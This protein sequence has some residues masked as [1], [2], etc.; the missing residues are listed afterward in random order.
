MV[1]TIE[2]SDCLAKEWSH[3]RSVQWRI[4]SNISKLLK[5][6]QLFSCLPMRSKI[7]QNCPFFRGCG[8]SRIG[9]CFLARETQN[10]TKKLFF[11]FFL[12]LEMGISPAFRIHHYPSLEVFT[13]RPEIGLAEIFFQ[14]ITDIV[15]CARRIEWEL[16]NRH[17]D[18]RSSKELKKFK[19]LKMFF[20]KTQP[21]WVEDVC[22]TMYVP[23]CFWF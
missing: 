17:K 10:L 20:W 3:S 12:A 18:Q 15:E 2:W 21:V 16:F 11:T 9:Q 22:S 1:C 6:V 4:R 5:T 13:R 19:L 7:V 14:R 8:N 23:W